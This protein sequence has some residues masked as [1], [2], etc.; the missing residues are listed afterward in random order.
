MYHLCLLHALTIYTD[1]CAPV[2][3]GEEQT[4][5]KLHG[6]FASFSCVLIFMSVMFRSSFFQTHAMKF[7]QQLVGK[8]AKKKIQESLP[9]FHKKS[10]SWYLSCLLA[11]FFRRITHRLGVLHSC[12]NY[13]NKLAIQPTQTLYVCLLF[14]TTCFDH[15]HRV[16]KCRYGMKSAT[17]FP[18]LQRFSFCTCILP[19]DGQY[20]WSKHVV[21]NT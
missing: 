20:L 14:S 8:F 3:C 13:T 21:E 19:D 7:C 4:S 16:E 1:L 10:L 5:V 2:I 11:T 6:A 12:S 17:D 18:L 15:H 9:F